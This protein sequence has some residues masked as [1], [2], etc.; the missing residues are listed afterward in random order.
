MKVGTDGVLLGAWTP[1]DGAQTIL[2]VGSGTGLLALMLAQR[3]PEALLRVLSWIRMPACNPERIFNAHPG[4]VGWKWWRAISGRF[5][6]S[7]I[8]AL[9]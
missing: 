9:I 6:S 7:P 8:D 1:V 3:A 4:P 2:D 5:L